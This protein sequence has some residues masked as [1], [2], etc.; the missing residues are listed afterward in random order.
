MESTF[1]RIGG[2]PRDGPSDGAGWSVRIQNL[3][4]VQI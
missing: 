2:P 4:A 1:V 3:M